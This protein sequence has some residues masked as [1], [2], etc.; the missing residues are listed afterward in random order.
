MT[1]YAV[2]VGR[3]EG[4]LPE[5]PRPD[6]I[7]PQSPPERPGVPPPAETPPQ[8]PPEIEPTLPD[9]D[10]PAPDFPE[11]PPQTDR[12]YGTCA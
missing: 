4:G 11:G 8:R 2:A 12:D 10:I 3:G 5:G 7:E 1:R 6:R 9:Q